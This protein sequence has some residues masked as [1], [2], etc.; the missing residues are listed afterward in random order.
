MFCP[1]CGSNLPDGVKFCQ[2]CG[3]LMPVAPAAPPAP[4]E[5]DSGNAYMANAPVP[6]AAPYPPVTPQPPKKSNGPAIAIAIVAVVVAVIVIVIG[7]LIGAGVFESSEDDSKKKDK[8]PKESVS[9]TVEFE[10]NTYSNDF[11]YEEI[12]EAYV[13]VPEATNNSDSIIRSTIIS[14]YSAV[15]D[16]D[17]TL[18]KKTISSYLG[19]AFAMTYDDEQIEALRTDPGIIAECEIYGIDVNSPDFIYSVYA[20]GVLEGLGGIDNIYNIS[21]DYLSVD[22]PLTQGE[23]ADISTVLYQELGI[24]VA[25]PPVITAGYEVSG[26]ITISLN[27]GSTTSQ[28]VDFIALLENGQWRIVPV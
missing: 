16:L 13:T 24:S 25:V 9:Q 8:K 14:Y 4:A 21:V 28:Y 17:G 23:L 15:I 19:E 18:I 20:V 1:N 27:D 3:N 11:Y 12:T 7:V 5:F 22:A 6:P 10:D 2:F 26:M